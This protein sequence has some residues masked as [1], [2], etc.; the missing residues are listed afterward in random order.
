MPG[1]RDFKFWPACGRV[2]NVLGDRHLVCTCPSVDELV[3]G[4]A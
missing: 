3:A 1:L 2:D 4:S